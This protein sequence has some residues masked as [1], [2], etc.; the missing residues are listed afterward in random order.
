VFNILMIHNWGFVTDPTWDKPSWSISTELFVNLVWLALIL[1]GWWS[2]WLAGA[3]VI[4]CTVILA[5]QGASLN[6][7]AMGDVF[8]GPINHGM[9]RTA[10]GFSMGCL[11]AHY[12]ARGHKLPHASG[13]GV[14]VAVISIVLLAFYDYLSPRGVDFL[15]VLLIYPALTL[16]SLYPGTPLNRALSCWVLRWLGLISYSIY[17][18]HPLL[19][20]GMTVL[21]TSGIG[22]PP[23]P[24]AGFLWLALL[25]VFSTAS[26]YLIE[27]P[28]IR[29]V[30]RALL[31]RRTISPLGMAPPAQA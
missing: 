6:Q 21:I 12:W 14:G 29:L 25:L 4:V 10:L 20:T 5:T 23:V 3:T 1:V 27:R 22:F 16:L 30:R 28:G 8:G 2:R 18:L 11:I 26:L 31:W 7:M 13:L 15:F 19:L 17:L 9:L 24:W